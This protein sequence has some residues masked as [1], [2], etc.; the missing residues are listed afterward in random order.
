MENSSFRDLIKRFKGAR[1]LVAGDVLLDLYVYGDAER[2]SPEVPVPIVL[3]K[4]RKYTLGG[5]GNVARN[6]AA[7]GGR[8]TLLGIVGDDEHGALVRKICRD[9]SITPELIHD[10]QYP[11]PLKTRTVVG[12]YQLLRVDRERPGSFTLSSKSGIEKRISKLGNYDIV[13]VSDYGKGFASNGTV[14]TLKKRFGKEKLIANIK[15]P[16]FVNCYHGIGVITLNAKEAHILTGVYPTNRRSASRV[17]KM[18]AD[19]F[20]SSVVLTRGADGMTAYDR[21]AKEAFHVDSHALHVFDVAGAGDTVIATLA[22]MLA[23][24]EPFPRAAE[25]A[26]RAAGVVVGVAGTAILSQEDLKLRVLY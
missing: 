15:P 11:T 2:I 5:A 21:N 13:V 14:Q 3:E 26:N 16:S 4:S 7:L 18:V 17:A 24:G 1:I 10:S 12:Q 8:V 6:I 20:L 23:V 25:I 22:T 19:R 9:H